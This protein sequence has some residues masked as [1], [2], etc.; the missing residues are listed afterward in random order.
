MKSQDRR[1][2][3]AS[4]EKLIKTGFLF[5]INEVHGGSCVDLIK[6]VN[7]Q[8]DSQRKVT[9]MAP[10]NRIEPLTHIGAPRIS[11]TYENSEGKV[12]LKQFNDYSLYHYIILELTDNSMYIIFENYPKRDYRPAISN[13]LAGIRKKLDKGPYFSAILLNRIRKK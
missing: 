12:K 13:F 7:T 6:A 8:D 11:F 9:V 1:K 2:I 4:L 3:K 5:N 10:D